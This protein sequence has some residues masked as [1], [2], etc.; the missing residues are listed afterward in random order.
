M[1]IKI[2]DA[3]THPDLGPIIYIILIITRLFTHLFTHT[4]HLCSFTANTTQ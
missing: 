1:L 4:H 2:K 3:L